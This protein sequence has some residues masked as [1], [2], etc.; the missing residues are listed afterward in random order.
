MWRFTRNFFLAI[1]VLGLW[2]WGSGLLYFQWPGPKAWQLIGFALFLAVGF[3]C[4]IAMFTKLRR[5]SVVLTT[6]VFAIMLG[7]FFSIQPQANRDWS[8]DVAQMPTGTVDGNTLTLHNVRDFNWT[9]LDTAEPARWETR[10]YDLSKIQSVDLI[11]NYW[12]GPAIAHGQISF[13]FDGGDFLIW[14]IEVRNVRG[15]TFSALA[16]FFRTSEL[17][18]VAGDERDVIR[19]RTNFSGEDVRLFRL[20]VSNDV[21]RKLLLEYVTDANELARTPRFYNTLVTNCTSAIMRLVRA[22]GVSVPL[23]WRLILNGFI[24]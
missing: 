6:A 15:Q 23:D 4:T 9:G 2:V 5:R 18:F 20:Q 13:G 19:R 11:M 1:L 21:A 16:G 14:S 17:V 10:T 22:I 8:S 12:M 24:S 3:F 7:W